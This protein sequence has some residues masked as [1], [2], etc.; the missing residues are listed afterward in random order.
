[1]SRPTFWGL[2][3][4]LVVLFVGTAW[5]QTR[6]VRIADVSGPLG[7]RALIAPL[8]HSAIAYASSPL[9]DAV[10][11]LNQQVRD[12]EI[13]LDFDSAGGYLPAV[14]A[15]LDIPIS[16]QMLV[17]S[18]TSFQRR[19]INPDNPRALY[20]NDRVAIGWIRGGPLLE[21]IAHD[22][23]QGAIFY[24]LS[25]ESTGVP[26]LE[27][28]DACLRCHHTRS[29][30][31]VPGMLGTSV[32]PD[33]DGLALFQYG[34]YSP[35]HGSP[36]QERWGGWYVT[37]QAVGARHMGNAMVTSFDPPESMATDQSQGVRSVEDRFDTAG[38]LAPYSDVV[39][40]LVFNHQMHMM[41]L[42]TRMGW[43]IRVAAAEEGEPGTGS[44]ELTYYLLEET[45][46]EL[47][48]YL[49]FVDEAPLPGRVEGTSGFAEE[50]AARGPDDNQGRSLRQFDLER[51]L[52][53]Y[54]CSYMIYSDAFDGLPALAR[55]AIYARMWQ[56]LSGEDQDERYDGLS[57]TDRRAIVEILR[58]TKPDLPEYFDQIIR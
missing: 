44:S 12:G 32:Y 8:H 1:M 48:D 23:R 34:R 37:G 15:A 26:Q 24:T 27:R 54:P 18:K 29:A 5:A 2:A 53:A 45:A 31:D 30:L 4:L 49:L 39:A 51:R 3:C 13:L 57:E 36:F 50:F 9:T 47:V 16:S 41:N 17:F 58:E 35:N 38:Y 43:E 33:E 28:Q 21:V 6:A 11:D 7:E 40:L 20:F 19:F 14:L 56:V 22:P 46:R 52:M 55:D 42:L 25:Q 10:S